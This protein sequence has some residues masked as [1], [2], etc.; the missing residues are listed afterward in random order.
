MKIF[1]T[2][3]EGLLVNP[4]ALDAVIAKI[5]IKK[6]NKLLDLACA[7]LMEQTEEVIRLNRLLDCACDELRKES[8]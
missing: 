5:E 2:R 1:E 4:S 8:A 3:G 6:L 7:R